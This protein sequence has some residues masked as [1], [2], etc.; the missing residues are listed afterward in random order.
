M[1]I[2]IVP[3]KANVRSLISNMAA[4]INLAC[5]T[6]LF[7]AAKDA[8]H[9]LVDGITTQAFRWKSLST[10]WQKE[11]NPKY[12]RDRWI[13]TETLM[14]NID[15]EIDYN[16]IVVGLPVGSTVFPDGRTKSFS[17]YLQKLEDKRPLFEPVYNKVR[18]RLKTV[19]NPLLHYKK[20]L[21]GTY[22]IPPL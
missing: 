5:R 8:K 21:L 3:L 4:D 16:F 9:E 20:I 2:N 19:N 18:M 10:K 14:N 1:I 11:K 15:L 22:S 12:K 7:T 13:N 6:S 17:D